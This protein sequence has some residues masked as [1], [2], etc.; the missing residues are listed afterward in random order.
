MSE[1][2]LQ[3]QN[4]FCGYDGKMIL[5]DINF[6]ANKGE[7]ISIIG[8]NGAGKTTLLKAIS[9][10]IKPEKGE[11]FLQGENIQNI[12]LKIRAGKIAVVA[13]SVEPAFMTVEE[14]ILL[15]RLPFFRKYQFLE[16]KKDAAIARKYM[17]LTDTFSLKDTAM[18]EI[19][20][21]ERQLASIARALV[22]EPI[23]LL[24]DEPTSHL[25]IT[26]QVQILELIQHLNQELGLTVLMVLHDLNLASEYSD[27]LVLL[28]GSDGSIYKEGIP[29]DVI[30]ENSIEDVYK[31]SVLIQKNPLSEKPFV[32]LTKKQ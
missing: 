6:S 22:Q 31:T 18:S 13:Q 30:T 12:P 8:P 19:S 7:V 24:L 21:G 15:G 2:I 16:T 9:N 28:S 14:Y 32:L 25:D 4:L 27:R 5:R 3:V 10:I 20:G 23:L 1:K 29:E 17:Q 26:H 11:I